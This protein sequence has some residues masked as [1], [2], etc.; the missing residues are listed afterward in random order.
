MM[1]MTVQRMASMRMEDNFRKLTSGQRINSAKDD[2]AGLAIATKMLTQETGYNQG[3]DNTADMKNLVHTAEGG[4]SNISDTLQRVRELSL[5]AANDT[6]D[7]SD[8]QIIQSEVDELL[9]GLQNTV[10]HTEFNKKKLLDG[11]FQNMNTASYPDGTGKQ[12]SIDE[13]SV[14]ALGL[15]GY[16]VTGGKAT[17]DLEALDSAMGVVTSARAKL[18]AT[19]NAFDH[20]MNANA[21]AELNLAAARSRIYDADMAKALIDYNK[22][23]TLQQYQVFMQKE[24]MSNK[25]SLGAGL[26]G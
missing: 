23:Q 7:S 1:S 24:Q 25:R 26:M 19:E 8:R 5:Q 14:D 13:M 11:S 10:D 4:L 20:T 15:N 3:Y 22:D 21:I 16:D 2:A 17:I 12:I 9:Q 18:G 6:L